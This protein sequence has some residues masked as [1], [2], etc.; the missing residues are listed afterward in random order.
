MVEDIGKPRSS[1]RGAVP[2][3]M[4]TMPR[5]LVVE[6]LMGLLPYARAAGVTLAIE[7][8]HPMYAADR[9]CINT[10]AQA[11][12]LCDKLGEG[13]GVAV[14]VYP[15]VVGSAASSLDRG[16]AGRAAVGV[17]HWKHE[18]NEVLSICKQRHAENC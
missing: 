12:E 1:G 16:H 10:L 5:S 8:L 2:A 6:A 17:S 3:A 4:L 13:I 18:P 9:A 15:C 14:D 11:N 7:P